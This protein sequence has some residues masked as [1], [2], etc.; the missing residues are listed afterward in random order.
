MHTIS[1]QEQQM[2][3]WT[4]TQTKQK[5]QPAVQVRKGSVVV[6]RAT[7]GYLPN[8]TR[9]TNVTNSTNPALCRI[10]YMTDDGEVRSVFLKQIDRVITY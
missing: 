9:A 5:V 2:N 8:R 4:T 1:K 6:I 10:E 7:T 3:N